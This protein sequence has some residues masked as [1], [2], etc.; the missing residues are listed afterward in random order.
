MK[1]RAFITL[2]GGAAAW[3]SLAHAQEPRRVI[4]FLCSGSFDTFPGPVAAFVQGLKDTGFIEGKNLSI[5][6]RWA[7]GQYDRLPSLAGELVSR[8][9]AVIFTIDAPAASAAKA[10]T[11][12]I[13]IV[14]TTGVDPV[15]A[16]LVDNFSRPSGNLTGVFQLISEL[17][18]KCLELLHELLPSTSTFALLVNPRNPN[19]VSAPETEAAAN[20]IGRRLEVLTATSEGDLEAAFTTMVKRQ[21]G[22]LIVMADPLFFA[23]REQLVA[24]AARYTVPSIYPDRDFTEKGGLMSYGTR[25]VDLV[26]Q[27]GTYT[28]KIL[29]GAKPA[30]LPV[31]QGFKSELVINLKTAKA[32]GLIIP[33]MLLARADDVIEK[34]QTSAQKNPAQKILRLDFGGQVCN[35]APGRRRRPF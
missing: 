35:S 18:P 24:L 29:R 17:G 4:G 7:E 27:A 20:A 21:A 2:L 8:G 15:K 28:G 6:W 16:G 3:V 5:E 14:F 19:I 11:K 30:D 34:W 31:Q 25:L 9:V 10:A 13:P 12:T 1:R 22:A 23:R 26:Q 33:P 32:L